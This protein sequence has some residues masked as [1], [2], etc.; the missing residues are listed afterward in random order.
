MGALWISRGGGGSAVVPSLVVESVTDVD[1]SFSKRVSTV[2]ILT[3]GIDSTFPLEGGS[4]MTISFSFRRNAPIAADDT[5]SD[6]RLW[7]NAKWYHALTDLINVWQL[8]TNGYLISY[9]DGVFD[10]GADNVTPYI[11]AISGERGY[12]KKITRRYSSNYNTVISGTI[13][14]VVGTAYVSADRTEAVDQYATIGDIILHP[15]ELR[16]KHMYIDPEGKIDVTTSAFYGE[17]ATTERKISAPIVYIA[18]SSITS[19]SVD[20]IAPQVPSSWTTIARTANTKFYGWS[21]KGSIYKAG[22]KINV[23]LRDNVKPIIELTAD[24]A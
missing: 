12:I 2:P 22:S 7:S 4:G 14:F 5:S 18:D 8:R 10:E 3:K 20:F 13:D 6:S 9:N 1:L 15:G 11:A 17:F 16:N 19:T 24:W 21:Y 23:D